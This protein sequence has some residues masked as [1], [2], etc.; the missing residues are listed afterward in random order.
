MSMNRTT[1]AAVTLA[2][3]GLGLMLG[4]DPALAAESKIGEKVGGEVEALATGLFLG[5]A[6]LVAI[7]VLSRRD[8]N[9][10]L[11]VALLVL[12]LGGFIFAPEAVKAVI[13]DLWQSI[14]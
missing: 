6:A 5:V 10:G 9:G 1:R 13:A 14:V 12:I 4:A 3:L 11:V 7:P 8:V 2:V